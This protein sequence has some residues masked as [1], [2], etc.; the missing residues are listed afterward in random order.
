MT[1]STIEKQKCKY[2][3]VDQFLDSK[4]DFDFQISQR[5]IKND[6][7]IHFFQIGLVLSKNC[8]P[9]VVLEIQTALRT[10]NFSLKFES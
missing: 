10:P 5:N 1:N 9:L 7:F 8:L 2:R 6:L 4:V 3:E